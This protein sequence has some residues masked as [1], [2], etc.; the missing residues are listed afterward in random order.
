MGGIRSIAPHTFLTSEVDGGEWSASHLRERSAVTIEVMDLLIVI[1]WHVDYINF[2][3]YE[4]AVKKFPE[5]WVKNERRK[6]NSCSLQR[7][8]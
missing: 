5:W 6:N 1:T 2:L 4:G 7:S 8:Q 3:E